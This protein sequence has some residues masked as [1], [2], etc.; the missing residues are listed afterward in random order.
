MLLGLITC[1]TSACWVTKRLGDRGLPLL[2][3][4]KAQR[5]ADELDVPQ[6]HGYAVW[7]RG[8]AAGQLSRPEQYQRAVS[9]ADELSPDLD[10]PEVLQVYGMLHL[11]AGLAA[12]AQTNRDTAITHLN[13]ATV[14]ADRMDSPVGTFARLWFGPAN[15][16]VWRTSLAVEFGDGPK[17]AEIA[18]GVNVE[19]IPSPS[20][21]AEFYRDLGRSMLSARATREK[22]VEA[23]LRAEKLAP[24]RIQNDVFV[25]EA[26]T[27][28]LRWAKRD[29]VGRELR[30]LAWRM[31]IAT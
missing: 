4:W 29:A 27:A 23:L 22:G 12:A 16:G 21:R 26:V 5:C 8:S 10:S 3:A 6:W 28:Q 7:L 11:S 30:G 25:R 17:V 13:E 18:N 14:V 15:V 20:R 24:Q 2:A 9:M 19:A 1:Y 31:G